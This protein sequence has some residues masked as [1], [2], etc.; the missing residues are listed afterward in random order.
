M[1]SISFNLLSNSVEQDETPYLSKK[2]DIYLSNDCSSLLSEDESDIF[3]DCEEEIDSAFFSNVVNDSIAVNCVC[4]SAQANDIIS[5]LVQLENP[6]PDFVSGCDHQTPSTTD[7]FIQNEIEFPACLSAEV[8]ELESPEYNSFNIVVDFF[9]D[10][11]EYKEENRDTIELQKISQPVS[12]A[13]SFYIESKEPPSS[14]PS[15]WSSIV[16]PVPMP[17][18]TTAQFQNFA[19]ENVQQSFRYLDFCPAV[20]EETTHHKKRRQ[21]WNHICRWLHRKNKKSTDRTTYSKVQEVEIESVNSSFADN[22]SES[23]SPSDS[24]SVSSNT[25]ALF[26][27]DKLSSFFETSSVKL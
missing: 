26:E 18:P 25:S 17:A 2:L 7:D 5:K 13:V 20:T 24:T 14:C 22:E 10:D 3:Y 11:Y 21:P 23:E 8:E 19:S 1:Q 9:C 15:T 4:S 16:V 6:I 12:P 27:S